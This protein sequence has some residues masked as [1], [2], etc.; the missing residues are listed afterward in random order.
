MANAKNSSEAQAEQSRIAAAID[1]A[2]NL[3]ALLRDIALAALAVLL[4]IFPTTFNDRL[5]QA[6]FE[7]GSFAGLKWKAK[8]VESDAGLKEARV[9]INDLSG[10]LKLTSEKLREAETKLNDPKFKAEVAK[11]EL[12]TKSLNA[13][14][15][16][17]ATNVSS[18]ISSNA[19]L[20]ERAQ[21][22]NDSKWGV[23]Y[24]GDAKLELAK[25]EVE[26]IAPKLG[27]PNASILV[28]KNGSYR[29]VSIVDSNEEARQVLIKAKQRR[30]DAYIV[31]MSSWCPNRVQ[32]DGYQLC[33]VAPS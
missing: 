14:A 8:L 27:I 25:Y 31:R 24:G 18:I 9:Q 4:L 6:G 16:K 15:E 22:S 10:Q 7:E 33:A 2:K 20:V 3:F 26:V 23:I 29:S 28:D 32:K 19:P 11:L 30:Q 1:V 5:T 17:V 21:S 13:A 12:D